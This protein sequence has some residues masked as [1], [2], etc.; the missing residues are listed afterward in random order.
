M[1]IVFSPIFLYQILIDLSLSYH[2]NIYYQ[3]LKLKY[4]I[5]YKNNHIYK[6]TLINWPQI[7]GTST[8]TVKKKILKLFF[9]KTKPFKWKYLAIDVQLILFCSNFFNVENKLNKITFK[10]KHEKNLDETFSN[11]MTKAYWIRMKMQLD[12]NFSIKKKNTL[13]LDFFI[14][15]F[16]FFIVRFF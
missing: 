16:I 11:L 14:T 13:N 8:I 5:Y 2:L 7:N 3:V 4:T 12:L 15:N 10:R 9:K 1:F 6:S